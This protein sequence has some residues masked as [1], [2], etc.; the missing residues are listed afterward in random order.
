MNADYSLNIRIGVDY[1][2]I[3]SGRIPTAPPSLDKREKKKN[4][5]NSEL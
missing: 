2:G 1:E 5:K 3:G 4:G